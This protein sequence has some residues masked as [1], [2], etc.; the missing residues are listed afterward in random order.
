MSTVFH[1]HGS[2]HL[3]KDKGKKREAKETLCSDDKNETKKCF[4]DKSKKNLKDSS[5]PTSVVNRVRVAY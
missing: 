2:M 1:F 5:F 4:Q 3:Q